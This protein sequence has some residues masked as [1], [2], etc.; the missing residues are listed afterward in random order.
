MKICLFALRLSY[1]GGVENYSVNLI[2]FLSRSNC[3]DDILVFCDEVDQEVMNVINCNKIHIKC[4][5]R[6]KSDVLRIIMRN[7][8]YMKYRKEFVKYDIFHALDYRAL[9]LSFKNVS[10]IIVTIHNVMIDEFSI[11][12]KTGLIG[13]IFKKLEH[14]FSQIFLEFLSV[15]KSQGIVVNT[16]RAL[17]R[18]KKLYFMDVKDKTF[19][20]P[21]GYDS[22]K[23][24]IYDV[25]KKD[26]KKYFGLDSSYN[27]LLHIGVWTRKGLPYLLNA[28]NYMY[29]NNDME[30]FNILLLIIGK[31]NKKHKE[32][33]P[34]IWNRIWEIPY[35]PE[36]VL[37]I[38][39]RTSDI[40]VMPSI[41]EGWGIALIEAL[42]SGIPVI[43]SQYV[44]SALAT[45]AIGTTVIVRQIENPQVFA[46]VIVNILKNKTYLIKDNQ[47]VI[48]FLENNYSWI[49][50][51]KS[52]TALYKKICARK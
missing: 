19:I 41:S 14:Y 48:N 31:V 28:L 15:L 5:G 21:A 2:K 8:H 24:N 34:N 6:Y 33:F 27:V 43:A 29:N 22:E 39:Y 40:F 44:P 26:A 3:I 37:P 18:L 50:T 45:E 52:Y 12:L 42:A 36:D 9:P 17:K 4:L 10:P 13:P 20:I 32:L 7:L 47:S 11:Q 23:Y 30:K 1:K 49:N 46:N 38:L 16:S 51:S 25:P 35:V